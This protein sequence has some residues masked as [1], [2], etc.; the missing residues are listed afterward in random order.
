MLSD[1][2]KSYRTISFLFKTSTANVVWNKGVVYYLLI[3]LLVIV[4]I[5]LARYLKPTFLAV[6]KIWLHEHIFKMTSAFVALA[7]A[8]MGNVMVSWEPYNQIIPAVAGTLWLVFCMVY[9]PRAFYSKKKK[10][11]S[12]H[13]TDELVVAS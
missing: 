6:K 9:F 13:T 5:D 7:S 2:R 4:L 12:K 1:H 11:T 3:Y 8:G 10:H